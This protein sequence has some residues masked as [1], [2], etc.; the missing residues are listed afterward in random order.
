MDHVHLQWKV[1]F[2][3]AVLGRRVKVKLFEVERLVPKLSRPIG[4]NLDRGTEIF[5]LC[6]LNLRNV[7]LRWRCCLFDGRIWVC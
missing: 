5:K 6:V 2:I 7:Y 1:F 4:D 3:D